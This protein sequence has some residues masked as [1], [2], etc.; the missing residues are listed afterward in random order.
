MEKGEQQRRSLRISRI[1][2]HVPLSECKIFKLQSNKGSLENKG[3][4]YGG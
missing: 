2:N 1:C 4:K 3:S